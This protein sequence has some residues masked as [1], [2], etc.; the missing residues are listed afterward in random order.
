[1][2]QIAQPLTT[3]SI[4]IHISKEGKDPPS[5]TDD[6]IDFIIKAL[7]TLVN[8]EVDLCEI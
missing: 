4:F 7:T 6:I 3:I 1:M 8:V 2:C 5:A